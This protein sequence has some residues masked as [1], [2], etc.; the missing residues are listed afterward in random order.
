MDTSTLIQIAPLIFIFAI[1]YFLM[2]RPQQQRQ[3]QL[4]EMIDNVR[5][6]DTVVTAGGIVGKVTKATAK[7]DTEVTVQ[8]ADGVQVQVVKATLTEVR[9]KGQ[10]VETKAS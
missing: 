3:K 2:I 10:P 1:M 6:G 7:E 8:I 9:A 4:R 5:R